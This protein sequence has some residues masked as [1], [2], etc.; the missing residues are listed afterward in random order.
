MADFFGRDQSPLSSEQWDAFD[1]TVVRVAQ[2]TL[3]GRRF[4]SMFGPL[5]PG[6]QVAPN[7]VFLGRNEGVVDMLGEEECDEIR[8]GSRRFLPLP[9]IHKDF[10]LHWRDLASAEESDDPLDVG[11]VASAA[12]YCARSEDELIFLGNADLGYAGLRNVDNHLDVPHSDWSGMGNAFRDVVAAVEQL[13]DRGF[14]GPFALAV[15]TR[16]YVAMNRMFENTGVLEIDQ[17]KKIA[18]A[19]VF[20]SPVLPEPSA[21]VVATGP[22]NLDLVVGVDM[23]TAYI[24]SSKMNHHFRVL[25]TLVLRIKRPESICVIAGPGANAPMPPSRAG[26]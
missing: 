7:D 21:I 19:G 23:R 17:I 2:R 13:T 1:A 22:E 9:I 15:S 6:T 25:E 8:A 16:S 24:E 3:V 14:P 18:A 10:M 4:I 26:V 20:V 12:S 11:A 5:G